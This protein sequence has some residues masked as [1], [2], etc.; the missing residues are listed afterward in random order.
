ML[1]PPY[2]I[3]LDYFKRGRQQ[4]MQQIINVYPRPNDQ[5]FACFWFTGEFLIIRYQEFLSLNVHVLE[6]VMITHLQIQELAL[7][8]IY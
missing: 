4:Q 8:T 5:Y 3:Q 6:V 7:L 1:V 2:M